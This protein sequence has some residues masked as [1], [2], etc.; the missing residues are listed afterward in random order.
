MGEYAGE[1]FAGEGDG[2]GDVDVDGDSG[3]EE[4]EEDASVLESPWP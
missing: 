2:D 3:W 4:H 1:A